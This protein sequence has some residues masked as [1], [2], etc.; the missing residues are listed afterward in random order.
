MTPNANCAGHFSLGSTNIPG[1][2]GMER[3]TEACYDQCK[4]HLMFGRFLFEELYTQFV[5]FCINLSRVTQ[6]HGLQRASDEY[7]IVV[8]TLDLQTLDTRSL[9]AV[10]VETPSGTNRFARNF[11]LLS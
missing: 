5:Q 4:L 7:V 10:V 3:I 8:N 11:N 9:V 1:G 6:Y 2:R